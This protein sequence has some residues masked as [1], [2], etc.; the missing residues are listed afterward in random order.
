MCSYYQFKPKVLV[1]IFTLRF[2]SRWI[3]SSLSYTKSFTGSYFP[4]K[5]NPTMGQVSDGNGRKDFMSYESAALHSYLYRE[6]HLTQFLE[7][8]PKI[9]TS[10]S[11]PLV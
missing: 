6:F 8:L 10:S 5:F 1:I 4:F 9:H 7:Q 11:D 2:S 3:K